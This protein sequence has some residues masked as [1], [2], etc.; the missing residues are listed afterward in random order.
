L[1]FSA[2]I[3]WAFAGP[4]G[5]AAQKARLLLLDSLG[6]ALAG[7]GHPR[8]AGF[9][10]AMQAGLAGE[11]PLAGARLA[12]AAAAAVLAA[13]TCWDEANEGLA[14]AHGRPALPVA[15][16]A[17]VARA[18]GA[19]PAL[20][21][22]AFA[23]G[24]EV[25]ARAGEA[26]RIRPGMHVDGSWHS[27]GAA[28]C[29]A[30]LAGLDAAGVARAVRLAS[31]QIPFAL[32]APITA[33]LDGR[34][35]YPA[36]AVLLGQMAAAAAASG[37]DAPEQGFAEARRIAL[38][39][40][41]AAAMAS[42]GTWLIEEAYQKPFAGV[43]H[44]HYAAA[45]ALALRDRVAGTPARITLATY[46]EALR[47]AG[48]RAPTAAISA[49]F[50]LSWA[51]A[52]ALAQGDLGPA[53]YT[54]AALADPGLRA[55]EAAV[56][57]VEDP[58][59]TAAGRRGATVTIGA[60]SARVDSVVGDPGRPMSEAE[61][62]AKFRRFAA[63]ALEAAGLGEAGLDRAAAALLRDAPAGGLWHV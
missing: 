22:A 33:G 23:L 38:G 31:C 41:D 44:A 62:L 36:H 42:P 12:P 6:C 13:A 14:R 7:I 58:A 52:A 46:A 35:S 8:V 1:S 47:Y 45:A 34:N 25:A 11:V 48:N 49:Q 16:L 4:R 61:T 39:H 59:L 40:A 54:E 24:Y 50:S 37:M 32:Y 56:E 63:P 15:P 3:D 29:A 43:R 27:L 51:V 5:A 19:D 17:L 2:V 9:A 57:L 55:L 53:A 10:R 20:V 21:L 28:A 60:A 30:R 18:R 26:W